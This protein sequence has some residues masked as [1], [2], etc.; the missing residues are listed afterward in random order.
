M[1]AGSNY[2]S[3][4]RPGSGA[5]WWVTGWSYDDFKAQDKTYFDRALS[6]S[7]CACATA[8]TR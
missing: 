4:W 1:A 7:A 8:G 2:L 5:Q 6:R 3:V